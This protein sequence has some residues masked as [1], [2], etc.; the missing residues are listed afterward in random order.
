MAALPLPPSLLLLR[1][2]NGDFYPAVLVGELRPFFGPA[3]WL[4][5][6]P[7]VGEGTPGEGGNV[8]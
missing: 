3:S 4:Y 1:Q 5:S 6:E 7:G 8:H 2:R